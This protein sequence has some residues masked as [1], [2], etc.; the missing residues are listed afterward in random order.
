MSRVV[1]QIMLLLL[2][3]SVLYASW[4][5]N[6]YTSHWKSSPGDLTRSCNFGSIGSGCNSRNNF[7]LKLTLLIVIREDRHETL[8]CL[9]LIWRPH[10]GSPPNELSRLPRDEPRFLPGEFAR[11]IMLSLI[12]KVDDSVGVISTHGPRISPASRR[13]HQ[14]VRPT[15]GVSFESKRCQRFKLL[16]SAKRETWRVLVLGNCVANSNSNSDI[17]ALE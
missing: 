11:I 14:I 3:D 4:D 9:D 10:S 5:G 15:H 17:L 1:T 8:V 6:Q 16:W 12:I 7:I 2:L 13:I